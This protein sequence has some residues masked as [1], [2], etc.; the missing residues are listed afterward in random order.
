MYNQLKSISREALLCCLQMGKKIK[1][2]FFADV[3]VGVIF[4]PLLNSS[5][6]HMPVIFGNILTETEERKKRR[7][8]ELDGGKEKTTEFDPLCLLCLYNQLLRT[9]L[10][11]CPFVN[12]S[13]S[14]RRSPIKVT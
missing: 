6:R 1:Y 3:L 12:Y 10:V 11:T 8:W 13:L 14:I 7:K 9:N 2:L 4:K 5:Q